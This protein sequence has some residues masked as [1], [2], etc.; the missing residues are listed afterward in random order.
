MLVGLQDQA[1][2]FQIGLSAIELGLI[3][4]K[5]LASNL[6]Y[7]ETLL[8]LHMPNKNLS[9]Q[10]GQQFAKVLFSNNVIR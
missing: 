6:A 8:A 5:I 4:S 3:R 9:D 7:N 1:T 10:E 2:P